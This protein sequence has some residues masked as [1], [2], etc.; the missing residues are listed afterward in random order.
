MCRPTW[1]ATYEPAKRSAR[2]PNASGIA[3]A[4][5]RLASI[6]ADQQEAHDDR[7]GIELVRDPGRVVPRPPDDEQH[8]RRVADPLPR[9]VLEQQVRDL[10]DR[11]YE[12][13]VV[14]ELERRHT[15]PLL[16]TPAEL[17]GAHRPKSYRWGSTAICQRTAAKRPF[18]D[19]PRPAGNLRQRIPAGR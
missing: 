18:R 19:L 6:I 11:E 9:Q 16:G 2:S 12:H 4:I 17:I 13:E 5:S 7:A 14:E 15:L 1:I 3:T 8:E 10:R